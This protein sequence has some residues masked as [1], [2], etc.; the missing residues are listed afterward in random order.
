MKFGFRFKKDIIGKSMKLISDFTRV[1][2][3]L[4]E[5]NNQIVTEV[6]LNLEEIKELEQENLSLKDRMDKNRNIISNL[7][8]ILGNKE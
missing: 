6:N 5:L 4:E 3:G 2:D 8:A 7:N 1:K